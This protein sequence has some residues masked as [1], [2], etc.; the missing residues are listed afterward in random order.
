MVY[1]TTWIALSFDSLYTCK[2]HRV[3]GKMKKPQI[4]KKLEKAWA[5]FQESYNG[6]TDSQLLEPGV[7]GDWSIRDL[8][9]HV[10]WWEAEALKHL[11]EL[12]KEKKPPRYSVLYG[13][14]DTFNALMRDQKSSLTLAQ[15]HK[16]ALETHQRLIEYINSIPDEQITQEARFL[17]RLR[18][19]TYR[20]YPIHASM[21]RAWR[22]RFG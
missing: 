2:Q 3:S 18:L 5:D 12:L 17:R 14:I 21:I 1:F 8:I 7:T 9:A 6:L 10:S 22:Q 15:V 16:E 11:P 4:L 20:H 19:D 13:G